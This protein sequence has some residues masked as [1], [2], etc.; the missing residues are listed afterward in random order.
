MFGTIFIL[1][2]NVFIFL[3]P[4]GLDIVKQ[5]A[6]I[7]VYYSAFWILYNIG[8]A[9]ANISH[10][11]MIPELCHSDETRTSLSLIRNS[12][13]NLTNVLAYLAS[14]IALSSGKLRYDSLLIRC[15]Q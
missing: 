4:I 12:M 11:A 7:V 2:S 6:E 15:L 8:Y 1:F 9:M 13:I 14:L 10:I 3:P 5:K